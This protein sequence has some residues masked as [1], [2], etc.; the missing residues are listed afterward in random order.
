[1]VQLC[2]GGDDVAFVG[3]VGVDRYVAFCL[4]RLL[5]GVARGELCDAYWYGVLDSFEAFEEEVVCPVVDGV[6]LYV[7]P[8][9]LREGGEGLALFF[10]F[11]DLVEEYGRGKGAAQ[12]FCMSFSLR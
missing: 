9:V 5:Y 6:D 10:L 8:G 4:Q 2:D 7:L 3:V 12:S 1:M 11:F